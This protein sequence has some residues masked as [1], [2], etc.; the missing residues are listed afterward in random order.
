MTPEVTVERTVLMPASPRVVWD[1]LTDSEKVSEWF[2]AAVELDPRL[3]GTVSVRS[4]DGSLRRGTIEVFEP[5]RLLV[6]RWMPFERD[7]AGAIHR[8][9]PATVRLTLS[10]KAAGTMLSV[11]ESTAGGPAG[12]SLPWRL[13]GLLGL[14]PKLE[15]RR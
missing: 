4:R 14:R 9:Q 11:T 8:R 5:Q 6:L 10:R 7:A 15:M 1:A 12:D 3:G 13:E 2:G